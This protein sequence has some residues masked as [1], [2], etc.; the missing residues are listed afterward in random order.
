MRL[1]LLWS[2]LVSEFRRRVV[3]A[4][5]FPARPKRQERFNRDASDATR[6]DAACRPSIRRHDVVRMS[7]VRRRCDGGREFYIARTEKLF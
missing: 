6:F 7:L 2:D 3:V 4:V 5:V 1:L